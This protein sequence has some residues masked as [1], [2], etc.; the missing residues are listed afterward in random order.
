MGLGFGT[1]VISDTE[2]NDA[3]DPTASAFIVT[4]CVM[5][6]SAREWAGSRVGWAARCRVTGGCTDRPYA[7]SAH[8]VI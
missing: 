5:I 8:W 3:A 1:V 7:L 6:A 2:T 4:C